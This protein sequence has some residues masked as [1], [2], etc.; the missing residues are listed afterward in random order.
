MTFHYLVS[1]CFFRHRGFWL[2]FFHFTKMK[3]HAVVL[4]LSQYGA[5]MP[6]QF[7]DQ[8]MRK[9]IKN[10]VNY[11]QLWISFQ[12]TL[13][14]V[15]ALKCLLVSKIFLMCR[16]RQLCLPFTKTKSG[17]RCYHLHIL[18]CSVPVD[19]GS[20]WSPA[21]SHYISHRQKH[22][23]PVSHPN[24]KSQP[25]R[26]CNKYNTIVHQESWLGWVMQEVHCVINKHTLNAF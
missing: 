21:L 11:Y 12:L 7:T 15:R 18:L 4:S 5:C 13:T 24:T 26:I 22:S 17:F 6:Q 23:V 19:L 20:I 14:S 25:W 3:G 8:H 9:F 1:P 2:L 10:T 16:Q